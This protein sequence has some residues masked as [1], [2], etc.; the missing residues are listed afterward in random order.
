LDKRLSCKV[1]AAVQLPH[2]QNT[3][4]KDARWVLLP[5]GILFMQVLTA[6]SQQQV[7]TNNN[8]VKAW[9][10]ILKTINLKQYVQIKERP[11]CKQRLA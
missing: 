7:S 2:Q 4:A 5:A 9:M 1:G 11:P 6:K 8:F 10:Y 3:R